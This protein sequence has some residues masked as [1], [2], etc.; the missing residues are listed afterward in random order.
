MSHLQLNHAGAIESEDPEYVHQMRVAARRLR[1]ALRMFGPA[2]P[3]GLEDAL[4]P[5]LRELMA[6]LGQTRDL[7]V[8]MEEIVAPVCRAMPDEPRLADLAGAIINRQ[9][10][11]RAETRQTLRQSGYCRLLLEAGRQLHQPVFLV[12]A[13]VETEP[14]LPS[15]AERRLRRLLRRIH[16][17]AEVARIDYPPSLHELR[18]AIKRMR[19]AIEFF[20]SMIQGKAGTTLIKRLAA[21]QEELGQLNDLASAGTL[22]MVCAGREPQLREGVTLIGG[23]HG[24]RH[25]AM[26][27]AI[28]ERLKN[29]R[30]LKMPRLV[31]R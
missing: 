19:Y 9:Y 31:A 1:A 18:I 26:L 17:L 8:L 25:A 12:P 2:L 22:L 20:D 13:T 6:S 10:R 15:F 11:A 3:D 21:L 28:E 29:L 24:P 30:A 27:A 16:D 7:D 5:L 14:T 23:W 4:A